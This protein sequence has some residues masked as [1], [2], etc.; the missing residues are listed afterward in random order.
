[1][2]A[3]DLPPSPAD[4]AFSI[5]A[6]PATML[7]R[8]GR[9]DVVLGSVPG[10]ALFRRTSSLGANPTVQGIS[11][12]GIA[13]SGASRALVTLDEIPQN[14]PFGGWVIWTGLPLEIIGAAQVIRGAGGGPYGAGAL[15]GTVVLSE[16]TPR[17]GDWTVDADLA[18]LGE[19]RAA[20]TVAEAVGSGTLFLAGAAE[21]SDGWIPVREGRGAADTRLTLTDE[22]ASARY[23]IDVGA[24]Q[25]A[26]RLA[27]WRE[28]RGAGLAGAGSRAQGASA[29]LRA[30]RAPGAGSPGW[31]AQVF[32][33]VS[34]LANTSVSVASG[35][36]STAPANDQFATPAIGYGAD[37]AVRGLFADG[38]WEVGIDLRGAAGES[39]EYFHP[40]AA[41]LDDYRRAGGQTVTGGLYGEVT[42][43]RGPVLLVA[44]ARLDGW[45]TFDGHRI[46]TARATGAPLLDLRAASRGGVEPGGRVAIRWD[47]DPTA[48]LRAAAYSG[49]RPATLNEL[50][51]PFRVGNDVTEANA[52]L[53][54]E[55]LYGAEAGAGGSVRGVGWDVT[56]FYN[57]LDEAI[58]NVTVAIGPLRD[59]VAGFI[60]AGGVLRQRRNVQAVN[61]W[62]V[63]AEASAALG[64]GFTLRAATS[65]THA[66]VEGG[67]VAPA[68]NGLAPAGTPGLVIT[69]EAAWRLASRLTLTGDLR[70]ESARFD[71]DQNL[72]RLA[73][74]TTASVRLDWEVTGRVDLFLAANN[75]TDAAVPTARTATGVTSYDAPRTVEIGVK[76]VGRGP[77]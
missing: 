59:P 29:S 47:L 16:K 46:E 33:T 24:T 34:D 61:A 30:A 19:A 65:W 9:L 23:V 38:T 25:G 2:R 62:G 64:A 8:A 31:R 76:I 73:A 6:I 28:D 63:E 50:F 77:G 3:A 49:F 74:A 10:V 15:T 44:G 12:R 70:Y 71:D 18:T 52:S 48:Y 54:P 39:R 40:T 58:V 13:G 51:R 42:R 7:E 36:A 69:G 72:R 17:A 1:M 45:S 37:G 27:A 11:I 14:D 55:R 35:R 66:R 4:A 67:N 68:L 56:G 60:P 43:R 26:A 75:L 53:S 22:A 32:A 57:R 5:V 41:G 21:H 20:G